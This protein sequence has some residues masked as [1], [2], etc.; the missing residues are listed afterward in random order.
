MLSGASAVSIGTWA[1]VQVGGGSGPFNGAVPAGTRSLRVQ[2]V[3][4][5][6]GPCSALFDDVSVTVNG[7]PTANAGLDQTVNS[8]A[9]VTLDGTGS[10]DPQAQALTYSWTQSAGPAVTLTG[11]NT[12]QPTFTA[13]AGPATLSFDLQVC[14]GGAPVLCDTDT[15]SVA[16]NGTPTADAGPDQTVNQGVT[17]TL[18]GTGSSDPDMDPLTYSWTQTGGPAVTL[19]AAT[20]AQPTFTAPAGPTV[21]TFDL[22]VCDDAATPSCDT[23]TVTVTVN[24][25]PIGPPPPPPPPTLECGGLDVTV[26]LAL[27]QLPTN[28]PDVIR[29]TDGADIINGLGGDDVICGGGG[30]D[31]V[32][33]N[34]GDERLFGGEGDDEMRGNA[35]DDTLR[36]RAGDD[37]LY[38][39][40]LDDL[41]DGGADTDTCRG[42]TGTDTA[43]ACETT[44]GVP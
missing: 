21:L 14:D 8:A 20:T 24:G 19:T 37:L 29:G 27:G 25:P 15:V 43:T 39:Q 36:G 7:V 4:G 3:M 12:A 1:Q 9:P 10:S 17:V 18:D 23:D 32:S 33:G 38:G 16:V 26:N 5:C 28:G 40:A 22:T 34:Q 35:G 2:V 6:G 41:L 44:V 30:A 31:I 11:A 13:P 42:G